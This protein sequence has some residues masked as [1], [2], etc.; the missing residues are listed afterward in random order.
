MIEPSIEVLRANIDP[1][2]QHTQ[3]EF[4]KALDTR[5]MP[6]EILNSTPN[7]CR[8]FWTSAEDEWRS[9]GI[10]LAGV[11]LDGDLAEVPYYYLNYAKNIPSLGRGTL[12][13]DVDGK[14]PLVEIGFIANASYISRR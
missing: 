2:G 8:L 14:I 5:I 1:L 4:F 13:L 6:S 10:V 3:T 9:Q 12:T 7:F 11:E